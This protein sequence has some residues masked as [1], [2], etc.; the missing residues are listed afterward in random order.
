[1]RTQCDFNPGSYLLHPNAIAGPVRKVLD[2]VLVI[3]LEALGVFQPALWNEGIWETE[4]GW[5]VVD[6]I[7][8]DAQGS[9]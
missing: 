1:M 7:L 5:V 4:P 2:H 3:V 9:P 6:G 8:P